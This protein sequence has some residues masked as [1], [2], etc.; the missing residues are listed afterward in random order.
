MPESLS[1]QDVM[2]TLG[3]LLDHAGIKT[4]SITLAADGAHVSAPDWPWPAIWDQGA[5]HAQTLAQRTLRL[6]P[7]ARKI[8]RAGRASKRLRVVGAALD[9]ADKAPYRVTIDP[10]TI[11][12]FGQGDYQRTFDASPLSRR[13]RLAPHLRGQLGPDGP[14]LA[15]D[16]PQPQPG[17]SIARGGFLAP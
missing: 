5:L 7:R 15:P 11:Q 12:V 13:V 2:R 3:T 6:H 9:L 16:A 8:P 17:P 4:A 10:E 1:Y 14:R